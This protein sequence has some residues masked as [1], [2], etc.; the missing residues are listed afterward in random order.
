MDDSIEGLEAF[1]ALLE[2]EGAEVTAESSAR[3]AVA[4]AMDGQFDLILSDIAMPDMSGYEL[5]EALREQPNTG[6][7]PAIALTGFGRD[8][9][10][11]RALRA[12]FD[13]HIGK[14]VT[15][16]ALLAVLGANMLRP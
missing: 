4:L 5:I 2:L 16:S 3:K 1:G 14:P 12:G 8:Q 13:A 6:N 9:D 7:V 10:A 11:A 15:L